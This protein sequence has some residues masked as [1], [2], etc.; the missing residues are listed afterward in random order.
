VAEIDDP[1]VQAFFDS[2]VAA[3]ETREVAAI[4]DHFAFALS[5]IGDSGE[6]SSVAIPSG[7]A[8]RPQLERL[9]GAYR[10]MDV[11]SAEVLD[12]HVTR[13]SPRLAQCAI[14]WRLLNSAS[15]TVYEFDAAYTLV[16]TDG[17]LKITAIAH[18]EQLRAREA[19]AKRG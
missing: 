7:D 17:A 8:W 18:N 13:M 12:A 15:A 9:L 4:G 5:V 19:M 11:T 3:F 1:E 10:A 2:Y 6:T 14:R 16:A